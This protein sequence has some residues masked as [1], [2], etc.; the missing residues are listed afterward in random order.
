MYCP[1]DA[2]SPEFYYVTRPV[3]RNF[4]KPRKP[5]KCEEC[6]RRIKPGEQYER[7]S[8]KW[9]GSVSTI[10]TCDHCMRMRDLMADNIPCFCWTH[11]HT[12]EDIQAF[13]DEGI[14]GLRFAVLRIEADRRKYA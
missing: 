12:R 3:A 5:Y 7:V 6:F 9:D 14:P 10:K 13:L 11:G 2:E 1:S 8:A 4:R